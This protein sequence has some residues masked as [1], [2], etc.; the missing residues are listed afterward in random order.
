MS[1]ITLTSPKDPDLKLDFDVHDVAPG[2][3]FILQCKEDV[4][5]ETMHRLGEQVQ[6]RFP[7]VPFIVIGPELDVHVF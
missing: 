2:A 1:V 4:D 7:D 5:F 3:R 6:L